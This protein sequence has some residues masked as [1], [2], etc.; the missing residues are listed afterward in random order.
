MLISLSWHNKVPYTGWLLK[1]RNFSLTVLEVWSP[2]SGSQPGQILL[3]ILF[4]GTD[5]WLLF[6]ASHE[7][8]ER[9]SNLIHDFYKCTNP[10]HEG[11]IFMILSSHDHLPKATPNTNTG[12]GRVSGFECWRDTNFKRL[13][14]F[15]F[16]SVTDKSILQAVF[17]SSPDRV[18]LKGNMASGFF[19]FK[20]CLTL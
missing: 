3:R 20:L 16:P 8:A 13:Y 6:V 12:M 4:L 10:I 18:L 7:R 17:I 2:R 15:A 14:H 19:W 1:S 9:G 5:Y 11:S